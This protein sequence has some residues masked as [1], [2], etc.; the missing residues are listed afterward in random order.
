MFDRKIAIIGCGAIGSILAKSIDQ[1]RAGNTELR[2]LFDLQRERA[3]ELAD[4][5]STTPVVADEI[6]DVLDDEEVDLVVEAASQ[7]AVSEYSVD[8]LK[9]GKDLIILSIGAFSD[10]KLLRQVR[11]AAE[12]S[13]HYIYLPSGAILG[14]DGIQ[15]AE[16]AGFEEAVLTTRKPP[17]TLSK[18]KFVQENDIDLSGLTEPRAVFEGPASEAV[19]AFPESVNVAAT[20]SLA[21]AGFQDTHVRIVADPSLNQNVH[22]IK[23]KGEAGEFTTRARNFPSPENPKTSYIA[24]LSAMR[25]LRN[26]TEPI[27]IGA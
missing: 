12:S 20:L 19:E 2:V 27:W 23:V 5:L 10:E 6:K 1:G 18:T 21:G 25:T 3:E 13:G 24:A 15:A 17:E 26:L 22:E 14:V 8:A 7:G 11:D 4:E 9:S 16:I